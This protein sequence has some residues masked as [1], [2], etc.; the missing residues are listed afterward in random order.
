MKGSTV[1]I[2]GMGWVGSSIA[3]SLL[4]NGIAKNLLLNDV[5]EGIA[6]GE[7]M[8]LNHGSSFLPA[9][10]ARSAK[11]SEMH[12]CD[13]VVVTAGRGGKPG[14]SRLELLKENIE[15][16]RR[17]S[18]ELK[19]FEGVL[20]VVSN[21]VDVLTYVYQK[22]TGLPVGKVIGTGTFLDSVRLR[23]M[24]GEEMGIEPKS[25]QADVLGEHG[26]SSVMFWSKA[27]IGG[28]SLRNW[29]DWNPE[30][31]HVFRDKVRKAAQEIIRRKGATNHAIGLVTASLVK[32]ILR[33]DRRVVTLSVVMEGAYGLKNVALSLPCLVGGNGV[34]RVLEP[35]LDEH[36]REQLMH[37]A[38]VLQRAIQSVD[39]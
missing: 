1:G 27:S 28:I 24:I 7:A 19:G 11:I 37:S 22:F 9:F 30:E 31:E 23:D 38:E 29:E 16:T 20:V 33:D 21:P 34:E 32:Y 3:I 13:V 2:I 36:E 17:I 35:R 10:N 18:E 8:D 6:E 26:D 12:H 4:Q 5:R 39:A 25:I 14:E 15:I